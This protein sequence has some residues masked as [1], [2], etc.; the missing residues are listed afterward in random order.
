MTTTKERTERT[1]LLRRRPRTPETTGPPTGT[2]LPSHVRTGAADT[3]VT[4][5]TPGL[6]PVPEPARAPL[7]GVPKQAGPVSL[8]EDRRAADAAPTAQP[9]QSP[10]PEKLQISALQAMCRHVFAFRLAMIALSAPAALLGAA[11]GLATRLVSAAVIA[12]FMGSYVLFRDWERFGPLLLRHPTLLAVDTLFGAL[13]LIAAG[14]DS[15]LAYVSVCT[16]LLA[17]LVYSWRGAALF[18]SLQSLILL[19]I[20]ASTRELHA[21]PA[22][23]ALFP[24]LCVIAGAAGVTLRNLLLRFGAATQALTEVQARLAVAEA[25]GAERA[26]LAREMHD[27]VAKTLHGVALAADGLA[28]SA[29]A[30]RIDPALIRQQAELVARS[31][32]RAA[33][34]A[35]ELLGD[36]RR[37]NDPAQSRDVL[38]ELAARARDFGTR[39]GVPTTYRPTADPVGSVDSGGSVDPGVPAVSAIPPAVA[40][41]LLS[42]A[43]EAME[44][45]HRHAEPTHVDVSGGVHGDVLCISVYDD[46]RG[47][48]SGT[49]LEQ[50]RQAGHFG[51]IGMVERAASVGA[52]IR[53]GSGDHPRGTEVRLELPLGASTRE[54]T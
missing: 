17:G 42:I 34:E 18:A 9:P 41:Q 29:S 5:V 22:Q 38:A 12:T 50:L 30:D 24:G 3:P 43:S 8:P 19:V 4:S 33:T 15:T 40:R 16:P 28:G 37:E 49:T 7:P 27:S 51:L 46:G 39:T 31:V 6:P 25:V 47:L 23:S 20:Y 53:I 48:P 54:T 1:R 2:V 36:L 13:L 45:A 14:P 11:P 10:A 21:T 35:R 44:N 52:R 26:R 32:R